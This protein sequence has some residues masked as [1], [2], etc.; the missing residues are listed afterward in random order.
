MKCK[1]VLGLWL[2]RIFWR[3]LEIYEDLQSLKHKRI[4]ELQ[5][6]LILKKELV[7]SLIL[8]FQQ[9]IE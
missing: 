2:A 8:P 1:N 3:L 9:T 5:Q 6:V 4:G 7:T